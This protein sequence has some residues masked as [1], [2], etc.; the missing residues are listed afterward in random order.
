MNRI[1][2]VDLGPFIVIAICLLAVW[3]FLSRPGL[4]QET[5][6][7]L[8]LFRSVEFSHLLKGGVAYPRWGPDFYFGYG[9][10]LFNYYAPFVYY[11]VSIFSALPAVDMVL[12]VKLVFVIGLLAS[13]LGMFSFVRRRWGE[14]AGV[15]AAAAYVYAPYIQYIDPYARGVLA[16]SFSFGLFPWV[17]W[18]FDGLRE[19]RP[20]W[21]L[22]FGSALFAALI[23]THNLMALV[24]SSIL[25]AWIVWQWISERKGKPTAGPVKRGMA[26]ISWMAAAFILGVGLSAFFWLPV[27]LEKDA[28]QL[29]NLVSEGG[30]FDFRNH[31]L[32]VG[33]LL[34]PTLLLDS[35]ATEP[36]F[37]F[38]LGL[39][40][41]IMAAG[42]ACMLA[43]KRFRNRAGFDSLFFVSAF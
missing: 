6:A 3:P 16:E 37:V 8:H 36:H 14:S 26:G 22:F 23:C 15:V 41:W 1:R 29:G 43:W 25:A 19:D 42:G 38:N 30:H 18:A 20:S 33:E 31:F 40:Q 35:G 17:L 7:E 4:P 11:L 24:Q 10:P 12:A 39:A 9:Y 34:R 27:I 2:R 5:D 21:R 13:G 32:T 28:V